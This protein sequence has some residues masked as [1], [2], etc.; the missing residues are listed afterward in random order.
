[1]LDNYV[2]SNSKAQPNAPPRLL[3]G[4]KRLENP[5]IMHFMHGYDRIGPWLYPHA[6]EKLLLG[7]AVIAHDLAQLDITIL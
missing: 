7:A 6:K 1:M 4:E 5:M 2:H 3:G